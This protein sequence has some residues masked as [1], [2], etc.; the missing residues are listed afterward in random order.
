LRRQQRG[1]SIGEVDDRRSDH[2][3]EDMI[4]VPHV[5]VDDFR[6]F[7]MTTGRKLGPDFFQ[8]RPARTVRAGSS[9]GLK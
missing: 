6:D 9:F 1:K 8:G 4:Q 7:G 2:G 5:V 3:R